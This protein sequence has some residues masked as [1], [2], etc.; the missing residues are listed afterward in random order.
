MKNIEGRELFNRRY[1]WG[2]KRL[3]AYEA[4][5]FFGR[6]FYGKKA[7]V[8][9]NEAAQILHLGC[10]FTYISEFVNADYFYLRW[11]PWRDKSKYDWL[12]DFRRKMKCG[13]NHWDGV[14]SEHTIE[15]L[16]PADSLSLFD[17][18][19]RTMKPGAW[20]RICVPDLDETLRLYD[21][22]KAKRVG[23]EY[24]FLD[25]NIYAN[26][27]ET[28]F[29]LAQNYGH[30]SVWDEPLFAE[31]LGYSGFINIRKMPYMQ[32]SDQRLLKDGEN[33]RAGSM[34]VEA[35]KPL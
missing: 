4:C 12:L 11:L 32:G 19:Y 15:H 16:H 21:E 7:P 25:G 28:I 3:F 31:L 26:R 20:M 9:K 18:L 5:G 33:R 2:W 13:D 17:E 29:N 24:Y 27:A 14:F 23:D 34:Y 30:V 1:L 6:M 35:Q 10:G 8:K 22:A